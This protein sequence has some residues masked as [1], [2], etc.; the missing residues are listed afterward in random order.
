M[1]K[2]YVSLETAK[3]LKEK[4]Y[5]ELCIAYYNTLP[6]L[7]KKGTPNWELEHS[8]AAWS[9]NRCANNPHIIDAPEL[10]E[11]QQWLREEHDINISIMRVTIEYGEAIAKED[12]LK[13]FWHIQQPYKQ[14][15]VDVGVY[16]YKYEDALEAGIS[17]ALKMI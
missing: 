17:E 5:E 11:V 2:H 12:M 16:L 3:T 13:Y 9:Y 6:S 7:Y 1:K 4:G 10:H 8:E 15:Q 14:H